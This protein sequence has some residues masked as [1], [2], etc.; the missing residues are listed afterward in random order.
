MSV[1]GSDLKIN[2]NVKPIGDFH[3]SQCEFTCDFFTHPS[4][5]VTLNKSELLKV[6]DD[7]YIALI[8]SEDLGAGTIKMKIEVLIPDSDY[9]IEYRK[10]I[11]TVCTGI[12]IED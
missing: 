8:K 11:E 12:I 6:D 2:I 7:N 9:D 10:E 3:I 5:I 4:R 1:I